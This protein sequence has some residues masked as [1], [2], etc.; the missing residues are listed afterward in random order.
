MKNHIKKKTINSNQRMK[1]IVKVRL[2]RIRR[3]II[4]KINIKGNKV[5][6]EI[7]VKI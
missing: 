3:K 4:I 5:Y 7:V 6:L 2:R 1:K